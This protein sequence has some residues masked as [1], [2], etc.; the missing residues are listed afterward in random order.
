ML[1]G[2]DSIA[3]RLVDAGFDV[4]LNNSRG[5]R[6]SKNHQFLD[7]HYPDA[8]LK[9]RVINPNIEK[10]RE[11]FWDYSYHEMGVYDQPALFK[12]VLETT[13]HEQISYVGHSQGTTQMFVALMAR[14]KFFKRHLKVFI[15]LAP[16]MYCHHV[17]L[18]AVNIMT[19]NAEVRNSI[20]EI[21]PEIAQEPIGFHPIMRN[22]TAANLGGGA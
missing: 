6:Y 21:G 16:V 12:L 1:N 13:G 2:K 5:N 8:E 11:A 17:N 18:E 4:W 14:Q 7:L 19:Y 22:M 10:A 3:F 20:R 15:A 9:S